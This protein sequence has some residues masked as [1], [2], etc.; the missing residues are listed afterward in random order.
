MPTG[1]SERLTPFSVKG[2]CPLR[3]FVDTVPHIFN[4]PVVYYSN[5][6]P[7]FAFP[8]AEWSAAWQRKR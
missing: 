4:G 2:T 1:L 5:E 3:L 7:P 8:D 6:L